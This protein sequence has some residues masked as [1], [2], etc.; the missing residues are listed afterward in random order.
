MVS[1]IPERTHYR[2]V[3]ISS[4]PCS[5][6]TWAVFPDILRSAI[7]VPPKLVLLPVFLLELPMQNKTVLE[8]FIFLVFFYKASF[9]IS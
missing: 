7:G 1:D 6:K 8:F 3:I 9:R 5:A 4:T 2:N